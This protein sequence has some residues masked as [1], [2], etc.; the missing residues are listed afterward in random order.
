[1]KKFGLVGTYSLF[2]TAQ[3]THTQTEANEES[4]SLVLSHFVCVFCAVLTMNISLSCKRINSNF[5]YLIDNNVVSR[6]SS[7]K[8]LG[9]HLTHNLSW[10]THIHTICAK[11]SRSLGYLRR[12]LRNS[13]NNIRKLAY[14]T[15]V[16]PQL[17]FASP[18]WSPY[19]NYLICM[20]ESVQNRAARFITR[21][22]SPHS[23]ITKIKLD[24]SLELLDSHRSIAL[25]CLLHKYHYSTRPS[26]LPLE[27]PSRISRRLHNQFSI[28][29]IHGKT[30]AFNSSALPR[31]IVLWND[32]PDIIAS[33][34]NHQSFHD[35]LQKHF[36]K[37]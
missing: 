20:L 7:Y 25:L 5:S 37:L 9:I 33:T 12:N 32:L 26:P 17:E 15:F 4:V 27:A 3:Q 19:Q 10:A 23:S 13:P 22:Y 8:Y 31:A 29:R 2:K 28:K 18:T 6:A 24:I 34:S 1:M 21:N 16:R 36:L 35:Q 30:N 11:A 14:Q